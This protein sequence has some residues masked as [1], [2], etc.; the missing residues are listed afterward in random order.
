M[1]N[2]LKIAAVLAL[3]AAPAAAIPRCAAHADMRAALSDGY[4]EVL[5]S[6]ALDGSDRVVETYANLETGSW[7]VALTPPGQM[8]CVVASGV[9]YQPV[10]QPAKGEPT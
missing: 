9:G 4:G 3:I 7:T 10:E 6:L 8:T 5:Q 2:T 1:N